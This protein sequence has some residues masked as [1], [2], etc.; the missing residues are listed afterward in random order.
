MLHQH[1]PSHQGDVNNAKAN[2]TAEN[3]LNNVVVDVGAMA[4]TAAI[5]AVKQSRC[6]LIHALSVLHPSA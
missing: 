6:T 1:P 5:I 4:V 2:V 3:V